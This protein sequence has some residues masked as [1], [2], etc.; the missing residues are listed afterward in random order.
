[1]SNIYLDSNAT[2]IMLTEVKEAVFETLGAPYNPSSTHNYGRK[3]KALIEIARDDILAS[4]HASKDQYNLTFT[5]NATEAN[6]LALENYANAHI[7]IST[8]EHASIKKAAENKAHVSFISVDKDG[9]LDLV[10]LEEVLAHSKAK[11]KL[12]SVIL[13]NNETGV[14]QSIY[15][16]GKIA[17]RYGAIFHTDAVQ[18]YGRIEINLSELNLDMITISSHKCG[19]PQGSAALIYN[20]SLPIKAQIFGGGQERGVRS[21]TENVPA[22]VGF[23]KLAQLLP[24]VIKR[25]ASLEILRDDLESKILAIDPK[26]RIF[27][28]NLLR[29][30]NTSCFTMPGVASEVQLINF[31]LAG[32]AISAGSACSSGKIETS[33]VLLAMKVKKEIANT[34]IRVSFGLNNTASDV[35]SFVESWKKIYR[36]LSK[37]GAATEEQLIQKGFFKTNAHNNNIH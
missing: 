20:K 33:Q 25:F 27:G 34:A 1:M 28:R 21:G 17:H 32:F 6:N 11:V 26:V 36:R 29:L 30:Q 12:V 37:I 3:A 31:D 24:V 13:A 35:E 10:E 22:I 7:I 2:A 23:G 16:I 19:G 5:S 8:T 14:L 15:E 18:A 9:K 4:I